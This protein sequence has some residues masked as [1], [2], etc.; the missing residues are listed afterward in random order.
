VELPSVVVGRGLEDAYRPG[1]FE[2]V[3]RVC[4]RLF[5]LVGPAVAVFGEKDWQQLKMV[6][7]MSEREGLGVRVVG[8][9]T[10]REGGELAG[11]ALSSRNVHLRPAD[12]E[13]ALGLV[14]GIRA[15]QEAG[16]LG[17]GAG[18]A[19]AAALAA[20]E[21]SGT[22]VEYA[23]VRDAAT[24]GAVRAGEPSRVL[25]AGRVGVTRLIDNDA[26]G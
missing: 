19:E 22:R 15:A 12:R 8:E 26:W 6:E 10:V 20:M 18:E 5:E 9:S 3:Y 13:A 24:C 16:R 17:G 2:G 4:R 11:V 7:A 1:H 25:V 21:R 14:R 23:A